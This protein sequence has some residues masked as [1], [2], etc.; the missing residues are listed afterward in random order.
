MH[1][2]V[3]ITGAS[4]GLGRALAEVFHAEGCRVSLFARSRAE[5]DALAGE[6]GARVCVHAG[7]IASR[8]EIDAALARF[9]AAHGPVDV[10][11]N[12]AGIGAYKPFLECTA[13]E[14]AAQV[15]VNVGGLVQFTHAV[16]GEMAARRSGMVVN[17][18]SDLARKPL[19]KMAVYTGT[20]H[21]VAGFSTSLARE[22]KEFGVKVVLVNPG[23][24]N[25]H[26]GG[27]QPRAEAEGWQ[28]DP[29]ELARLVAHLAALPPNM[30]VDEVT[31]HPMGQDF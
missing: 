11:V 18:A 24:I 19:A 6:L 15:A 30:L 26:F 21:A 8:A 7:D 14:L 3:V 1:H 23:I 27:G 25:T 10:L 5:L 17:I 29:A 20:K 22:L 28:L 13:E 16:A 9:R 4:R 2:H 12:N 31:V